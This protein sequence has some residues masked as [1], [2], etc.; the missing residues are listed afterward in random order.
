MRSLNLRKLGVASPILI[1]ALVLASCGSDTGSGAVAS[2][3]V[4]LDT[5]ATNYIVKDPVTTTIAPLV[6]EIEPVASGS[7]VYVVQSGDYPLKVADQFGVPLEVLL[8]FNGW[9]TGSEFPFPGQD[10]LIPPGAVSAVEPATEGDSVAAAPVGET[11]P[12]SGSNCPAGQY[13]I[14]ASDTARTMVA[15]KFDVTVDALD[16]ANAGTSGY[17]AFYPGLKIVIPAKAGC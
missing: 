2:T 15:E 6:T 11:I 5:A 4:D 9:A 14:E 16:A 8:A 3:Q 1:G 17:S 13:T 10:V 12:D 7:Q